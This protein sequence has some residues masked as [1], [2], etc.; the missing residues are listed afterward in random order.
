MERGEMPADMVWMGKIIKDICFR[1][2][3]QYFG[4]QGITPQVV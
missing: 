1:N 4:W 2:A 3:Q